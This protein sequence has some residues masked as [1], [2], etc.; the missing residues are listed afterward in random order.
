M[1]LSTRVALLTLLA[2]VVAYAGD[3]TS[4]V[5]WPPKWS[6]PG[7]HELVLTGNAAYDLNEVLGDAGPR[8]DDAHGWRR[9]E[10]GFGL[11]RKGVYDLGAAFDFASR[12]WMDVAVRVETKAV[13]GRDVG[14]VRLG[15]TKLPLG[16][17]GNTATRSSLFLENSL[18]TQAF[19][20]GRRI[21]LDWAF[22]QPA[23]LVNAGYY[24]NDLQGNNRGRV[25]A[26]RAAWTPRKAAG[27]VLHLG[28]AG[29]RERPDG[30]IDGRGNVVPAS[31]RWRARPEAGLTPTRLVDSGTLTG[32]ER[33]ERVGMEALWIHGP[34][35]LQAEHMGQRTQR[36]AGRPSYAADGGYIAGS[37]ILTGESRVYT[38][39]NVG[40]PVPQGSAGAFELTARRSWIDLDDAGIAGGRQRN[41]TVGANWYPNRYLKLQANYVR[42]DATRGAV[43]TDGDLFLLRAQTHF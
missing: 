6:L 19:Y 3:G 24:G 41:W 36:T 39:G 13:T 11:K 30:E 9:R 10:F 40:N 5:A 2:P 32:A 29:T 17:E 12:T 20:P 38:G 34:W 22:E 15:Q 18:P 42:V 37:W 23:Y 26:A 27:D 35:S 21:G 7:E 25:F 33:V 28:I 14:R 1:K 8:L 4:K 43:S 31:A 16:F